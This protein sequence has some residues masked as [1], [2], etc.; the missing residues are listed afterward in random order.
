M[1]DTASELKGGTAP[2]KVTQEQRDEAAATKFRERVNNATK[3][4]AAEM[5]AE[6]WPT[7]A[8]TNTEIRRKSFANS[9]AGATQRQGSGAATLLTGKADWSWTGQRRA[10]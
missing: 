5:M 3:E 8:F 2:P 4:E 6:K 9:D 10:T 7:A 1:R